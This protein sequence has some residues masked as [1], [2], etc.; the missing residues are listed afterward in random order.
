[1][2]SY[3]WFENSIDDVW[4]IIDSIDDSRTYPYSNELHWLKRVGYKRYFNC[5]RWMRKLGC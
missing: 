1:M 3:C 5:S 2:R 4:G